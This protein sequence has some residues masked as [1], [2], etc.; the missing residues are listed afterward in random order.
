MSTEIGVWEIGQASSDA[1]KLDAADRM[2]TEEMLEDILTAN[3]NMLLSGLKLVGRQVPVGTGQ[4]DLLGIDE[5]GRLVVFELKRAKLTREAV[6]QVLDYGTYLETLSDTDLGDLI[7]S[8]S[9]VR[10]I[11]RIE[12]FEEWYASEAGSDLRPIRMVLVGLG[13]DSSAH[14]IVAYLAEKG[15]DISLLT[16]HGYIHGDR[17]LL[18]KQVQTVEDPGSR[19]RNRPSASDLDRRANE[20]GVEEVWRD[21]RGSLNYSIRASYT[22]SGIT[23]VQRTITLP[24]AVRVRGSHSIVIEESGHIRITFY[25]AAVHLCA[26]RFEALKKEI[27]FKSEN[28]PNAPPTGNVPHQWYCSLDEESWRENKT[29]LVEFVRHLESVWRGYEDSTL[30]ESEGA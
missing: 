23:F 1:T 14:R 21:A 18:A 12:D 16:F 5:E 10:G 24:N 11:K 13:I 8:G 6:A 27:P 4:V 22:K 7:A 15:I 28:P 2:E 17:M 26:D 3:P 20:Y 29:R 30:D 19:L 25:P 9:G